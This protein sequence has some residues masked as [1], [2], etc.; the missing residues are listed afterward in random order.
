MYDDI[1]LIHF[2]I[3]EKGA[4]ETPNEVSFARGIFPS[5]GLNTSRRSV[6]PVPSLQS[7]IRCLSRF[8]SGT[9]E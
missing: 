4:Y 2:S 6:E 8:N 9:I 1:S 5:S 7:M 3:S